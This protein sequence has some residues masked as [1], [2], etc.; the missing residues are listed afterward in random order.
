MPVVNQRELG[1]LFEPDV[2][3]RRLK[4]APHG[5]G[6]THYISPGKS[7]PRS[8]SLNP[9]DSIPREAKAHLRELLKQCLPDL[10]D[11]P[12]IYERM[13]WDA[14]WVH[15]SFRQPSETDCRKG[16]C[17]NTDAHMAK[18]STP[19]AHFLITDHPDHK[20]LF[21]A[22]GASAHG[23][24]VSRRALGATSCNRL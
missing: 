3:G 8:K 19:D 1:Y 4:I 15:D 10:A 22:G 24:K 11:R 14:E 12:F 16:L 13:C 21:V 5:V 20:N 6:Y 9:S 17:A 2:E 7:Y 23:F 18:N